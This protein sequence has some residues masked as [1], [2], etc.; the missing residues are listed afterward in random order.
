MSNESLPQKIDPFRFADNATRLKGFFSIEKMSRLSESLEKNQSKVEVTILCDVDGQGNR[1]LKGHLYAQLDL[2]CQRCMQPFD[3]EIITD[4]LWGIVQTEEEADTLPKDYD[5]IVV[6]GAELFIQDLI[7][8]ELIISLPIV[9]M[10]SAEACKVKMPFVAES[11]F[12]EGEKD[13]PF[14]V[15]ELLRTKRKNQ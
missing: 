10:H 9:P 15:I 4:F 12:S 11:G 13:N 6:K 3:Y 8:D 1:F 2:K 14:K 7:E 5:P